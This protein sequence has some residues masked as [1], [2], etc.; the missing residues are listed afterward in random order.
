MY[1]LIQLYMT[2]K[3][4]LAPQ[5]PLLKLFAIKAVGSYSRSA[6]R[7][8]RIVAHAHNLSPVFLTFWQA[9]FLS[10]LTLF[11]IV[12]DVRLPLLLWCIQDH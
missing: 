10:V 3:V 2:V 5:K 12:K 8:T 4:E 7:P 1:C 11:G 6:V 9:T